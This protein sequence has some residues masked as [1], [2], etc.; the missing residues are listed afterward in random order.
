LSE[1][2]EPW[3][4]RALILPVD[5][6]NRAAVRNSISRVVDQW[7]RVD[8]LVNSAGQSSFELAEAIQEQAEEVLETNLLGAV[9]ATQAVLPTMRQAA[10]GQIVF[11][12]SLTGHV[13]PAGFAVYAMSKWGL[14][15]L[16]QSLRAELRASGIHVSLVSPVY[17]RTPMLEFELSRG[18]LPGY[19]PRNVLEPNDVARAI[20]A[21]AKTGRRELVLAPW[22]LKL[23]LHFGKLFPDLQEVVL[24]RL[25]QRLK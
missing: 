14:R 4:E 19:N 20:L 1:A 17:V 22:W 25:A 8:L 23:A 16:V 21:V 10:R 11:V 12:G 3:P 6:R 2:A 7:G 24:A 15:A 18:G 5:V 13:A 9:W